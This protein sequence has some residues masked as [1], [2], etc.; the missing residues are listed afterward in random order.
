MTRCSSART[1]FS[2]MVRS[3][4]GLRFQA[5]ELAFPGM[6]RVNAAVGVDVA[7]GDIDR[8]RVGVVETELHS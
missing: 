2:R 4:C 7:Q 5:A 8:K 6:Q 3:A 1:F